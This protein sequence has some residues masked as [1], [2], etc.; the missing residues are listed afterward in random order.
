MAGPLDGV[1]VIDL[2]SMISGPLATM[3]LADQGADV[4]KVEAPGGGDFARHVATRRGGFS[5]SFVNNNRN[6]RSIVLDL[7]TDAGL[8]ALKT[9]IADA[10]VVAQNFRPGVAERMGIGEAALRAVNPSLIYVSICGFGF[11]GPYAQKPTFDP[12][13][14][15]LA[16]LTTVQAGNDEDRP[17]LV[18]TILPDKLTAIQASQAITAALFARERTGEGQHVTLSMLDTIVAFLWRSDMGGHTFV[19]DEPDVEEAQS[20]ID[21]IYETADGYISVAAM[22]DKHWHGL[23]RAV[24]RPDFITDARF[25]TP[26]LRDINRDE[27][28]NLTQDALRAWTTAELL[29]RLEAED[30]PSAP[31]LTRSEMR[32]HPQI[33]ANGIIIETDHPEAGRLRQARQPAEFSKTPNEIRFGAPRLGADTA[34]VLREGGFADAEIGKLLSSGAAWQGSGNDDEKD[35]DKR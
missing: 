15:A 35:D 26:E 27:R 18:R 21:L 6:K 13:V 7:K 10:D 20:F 9:L 19:G 22:H 8:A 33:V 34:A 2:T 25:T 4:I 17:R 23:S 30:V 28:I 31:V 24:E 29:G 12:L 16:G 14:Q 5:A 32:D 1:R 3:T 11:D